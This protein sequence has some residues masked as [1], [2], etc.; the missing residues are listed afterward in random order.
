MLYQIPYIQGINIDL[1]CYVSYLIYFK[2]SN[3]TKVSDVKYKLFKLFKLTF[4][5][6]ISAKYKNL[7]KITKI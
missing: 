6:V 5:V 7:N 3:K 2:I 1:L 4:K